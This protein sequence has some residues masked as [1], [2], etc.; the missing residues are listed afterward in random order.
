MKKLFSLFA[1]CMILLLSVNTAFAGEDTTEKY[2]LWIGSHYTEF[3]DYTKQVGKYDLGENEWLPEFGVNYISKSSNGMFSLDGHYFDDHNVFGKIR[4]TVGDKFKASFQYRSMILQEGQDLLTV[5][6][7]REYLPS[8][9]NA[10]GKMLTHEILDPDA[11]Y[12]THRQEISSN[13]NAKLSNKYNMRLIVAHRS[14]LKSGTE[15]K[16]AST[17]CFSCHLTSITA[18]VDQTQH[19]FE[20]GIDAS[21]DKFDFGYRFGYRVFESHAVAPTTYYDDARHPV[22]M[23][24]RVVNLVL[25]LSMKIL[26]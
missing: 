9:G 10:G 2:S 15:Q 6:E 1:V 5:M 8:S 18:P 4:T 25:G 23:V 3:E 13:I 21:N 16:I 24:V 11:D 22:S 20:A 17:H 19:Q 14:I 7:A 12:N 26:L